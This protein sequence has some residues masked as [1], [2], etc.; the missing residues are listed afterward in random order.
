MVAHPIR[1]SGQQEM[2]SRFSTQVPLSNQAFTLLPV[3]HTCDGF[4]ARNHIEKSAIHTPQTCEVFNEK[5]TYLFYGRP[6]FK[7]FVDE[8]ATT[9]LAFYPVCFVLNIDHIG[10]IKRL[11]PFDTGAMF[12][13]RFKRYMHPKQAVMDFE[14]EPNSNRIN[15]VVLHFFGSS[16]NYLNP[17]PVERK[18]DSTDFEGIAYAKMID[19]HARSE[20]DERRITIEVQADST[21]RLSPNSLRAIILPTQLRSSKLYRDFI[22]RNKIR[23]QCYDIEVWNPA[24]SFSLVSAAAKR[25]TLAAGLFK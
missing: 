1:H 2:P 24:L 7:Y 25:L 13:N 8:D 16:R 17:K 5:I 19:S 22:K 11:F 4:D 3:Y 10:P 12:H 21:V 15:D 9:N 18:F 23:A 14:L 6:A 20:A